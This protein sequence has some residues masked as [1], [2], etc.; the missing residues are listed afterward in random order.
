MAIMRLPMN[1]Q[2]VSVKYSFEISFALTMPRS[3]NTTIGNSAVIASGTVSVTQRK[4]IQ[5]TT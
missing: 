1:T 3:G 4:A 5:M 2:F